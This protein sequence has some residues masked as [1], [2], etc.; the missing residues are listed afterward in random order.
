MLAWVN[1]FIDLNKNVY[2]DSLIL[3]KEHRLLVTYTVAKQHVK[4]SAFIHKHVI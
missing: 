3:Q 1:P 2:E 4:A